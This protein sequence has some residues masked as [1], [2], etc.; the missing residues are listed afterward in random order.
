[1]AAQRPL[2]LTEGIWVWGRARGT[3]L[4]PSFLKLGVDNLAALVKLAI[5]AGITSAD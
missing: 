1:M 4:L 3:G 5:R 2:C